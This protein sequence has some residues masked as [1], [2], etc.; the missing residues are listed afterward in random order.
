MGNHICKHRT[1]LEEI[2]I[3]DQDL[4]FAL[5]AKPEYLIPISIIAFLVVVILIFKKKIFTYSKKI[6][7]INFYFNKL[8]LLNP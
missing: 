1:G 4:S 8:F 6:K 3:E 7:I 5:I 2:F